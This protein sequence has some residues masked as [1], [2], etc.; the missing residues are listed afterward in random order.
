MIRAAK[1]LTENDDI[2][3][4]EVEALPWICGGTLLPVKEMNE[5]FMYG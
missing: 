4:E 3:P 1:R 2:T 5:L